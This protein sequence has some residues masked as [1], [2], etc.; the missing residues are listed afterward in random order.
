MTDKS[1]VRERTVRLTAAAAGSLEA[2]R[3]AINTYDGGF[4]VE[5]GGTGD[6]L[7]VKLVPVDQA[8]DAAVI[9]HACALARQWLDPEIRETATKANEARRAYITELRN[10]WKEGK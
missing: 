7:T 9:A 2:M 8:T 6:Q 1:R 3:E 5:V 4:V 10:A